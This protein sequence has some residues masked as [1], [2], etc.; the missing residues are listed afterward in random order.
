MYVKLAAVGECDTK[1][2]FS[3]TTTT[4]GYRGGHKSFP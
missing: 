3:I 4:P 1:A 2:P